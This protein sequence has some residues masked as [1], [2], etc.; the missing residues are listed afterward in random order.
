MPSTTS[1]ARRPG[2]RRIAVAGAALA[3]AVGLVAGPAPA[4]A[5]PHRV[6]TQ[7]SIRAVHR[8]TQEGSVDVVRGRLHAHR[9]GL[10]NQAVLLLSRTADADGW[11]VEARHRTGRRG[12]VRFRVDPAEPTAYR[13]AFRGTARLERARSRAVRVPVRPDVRIA[14]DPTTLEQGASTTISGQVGLQGA[15][16]A[17]TQVRL[18]AVKIG[19]PRSAR[20]L[21]RAATDADGRVAFTATPRVSTRYRL[22]VAGGDGHGRAWSTV[23]RVLVVPPPS[24]T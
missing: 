9:V 18:W 17:D 7:L 12:M 19:R 5:A 14:A 4:Q 16:L 2:L 11:T 21:D 1:P 13:L 23:V 15:P 3:T 20:F 8:V 6:E 10:G 24:V 22:V